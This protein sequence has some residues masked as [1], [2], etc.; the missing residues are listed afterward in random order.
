MIKKLVFVLIIFMM[1]MAPISKAE[2][3][4]ENMYCIDITWGSFSFI[5]DRGKWNTDTLQYEKSYS[6]MSPANGTI[7][8]SIGW[9]GFNG[10][11]NKISVTNSSPEKSALVTLLATS[12]IKD[13]ESNVSGISDYQNIKFSIYANNEWENFDGKDETNNDSVT[14]T[15]DSGETLDFYLSLSGTPSQTLPTTPVQIGS[16]TII[17]EK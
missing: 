11:A 2:N 13:T 14:Q 17:V 4:V 5:Y 10:E 9:Y 12:D 6:S 15:L 16:F 3:G 1:I 8:G 7:D